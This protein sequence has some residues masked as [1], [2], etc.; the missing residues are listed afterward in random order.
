MNTFF[1]TLQLFFASG[2]SCTIDGGRLSGAMVGLDAQLRFRLTDCTHEEE[3]R[4]VKSMWPDKYSRIIPGI[5]IKEAVVAQRS[6]MAF[7]SKKS[8]DGAQKPSLPSVSLVQEVHT[9]V[10]LRLDGMKELAFVWARVR[11]HTDREGQTWSDVRVGSV[12]DDAPSPVLVLPMHAIKS[13][14]EVLLVDKASQI[15]VTAP[16]R[17]ERTLVKPVI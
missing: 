11:P 8:G 12:R 14:G 3:G 2:R 5:R 13:G 7:R 6:S 15:R 4:I 9:V 17:E 16:L 1:P 10:G